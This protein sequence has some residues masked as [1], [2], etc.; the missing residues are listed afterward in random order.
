MT[1]Q[2]QALNLN[3]L[4]TSIAVTSAVNCSPLLA[5]GVYAV[6]S[7]TQTNYISTLTPVS[8]ALTVSTGFPVTVAGTP[9]LL[10]IPQNGQISAVGSTAGTLNYLKVN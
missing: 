3:A 10:N 1:T 7:L 5:A 9:V 2:L 4:G 6:W 8:T